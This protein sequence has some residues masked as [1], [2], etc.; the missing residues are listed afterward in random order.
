LSILINYCKL[1]L[2]KHIKFS[3]F[4]IFETGSNYFTLKSKTT[5]QGKDSLIQ[6]TCEFKLDIIR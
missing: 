1:N 3:R 5:T 4:A 6:E 2:T